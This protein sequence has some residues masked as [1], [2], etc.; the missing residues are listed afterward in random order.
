MH[1][2]WIGE[3]HFDLGRVEAAGIAGVIL[4]FS[5]GGKPH[6]MVLE[7]MERFMLAIAP[8]FGG[9]RGGS[10]KALGQPTT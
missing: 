4:H 3:H 6:A 5:V 1:S 2:A 10:A 8:A 9:S 7:Q